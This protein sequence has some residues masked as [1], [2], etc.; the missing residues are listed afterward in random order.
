[1]YTVTWVWQ[2]HSGGFQL[3]TLLTPLTPFLGRVVVHW[4]AERGTAYLAGVRK[5]DTILAV[6][7]R[8]KNLVDAFQHRR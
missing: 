4:V 8:N 7:D 1:M 3:L 5:N 2:R 6:N